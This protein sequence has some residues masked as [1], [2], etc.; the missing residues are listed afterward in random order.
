MSDKWIQLWVQ[1]KDGVVAN[2]VDLMK[3]CDPIL[4]QFGAIPCAP[5]GVPVR[6]THGTIEV[7][8]YSEAMV[9]MIKNYLSDSGFKIVREQVNN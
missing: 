6:S 8:V 2:P 5:N 7:R 4:Q 1:L 9:R 3:Q